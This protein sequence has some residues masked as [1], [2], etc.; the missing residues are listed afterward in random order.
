[1]RQKSLKKEERTRETARSCYYI[2]N[3]G[4]RKGGSLSRRE[5]GKPCVRIHRRPL[6][7]GLKVPPEHK[8][9][10]RGLQI[11]L[12]PDSAISPI[13]GPITLGF[14]IKKESSWGG[15]QGATFKHTQSGQGAESFSV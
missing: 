13:A 5:A 15:L 1:M 11:K 6:C 7:K 10:N 4:C 9:F 8:P 12:L 14:N 2:I 3:G